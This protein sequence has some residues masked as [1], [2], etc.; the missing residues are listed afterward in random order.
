[1][2]T[3]EEAINVVIT[4]TIKYS[5]LKLNEKYNITAKL[6]EV[7]DDKVDENSPLTIAK[8]VFTPKEIR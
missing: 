2:L 6:Y 5:R 4:D 1:M 3:S 8:S 7:V